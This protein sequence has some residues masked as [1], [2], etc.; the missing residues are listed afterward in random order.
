M[1]YINVAR[2]SSFST[3][4]PEKEEKNTFHVKPRVFLKHFSV[5]A[6]L[7]ATPAVK[8]STMQATDAL[9]TIEIWPRQ[10]SNDLQPGQFK[11]SVSCVSKS[12]EVKL[13]LG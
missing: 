12:I 4:C 5:S 1:L 9:K 13:P 7:S 2:L 6:G 10:F 8:N 3:R 11:R